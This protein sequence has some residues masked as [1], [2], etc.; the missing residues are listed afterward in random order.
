MGRLIQFEIHAEDPERAAEFY[1]E[2]FGWG[3]QKWEGPVD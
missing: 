1:R 2:V 3:I